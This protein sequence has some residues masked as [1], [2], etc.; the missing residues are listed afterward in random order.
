MNNGN[1]VQ[2]VR[3]QGNG[4]DAFR[5]GYNDTFSPWSN[6]NDQKS[7]KAATS[8]GFKL[9]NFSNNI[10]TLNIYNNLNEYVISQNTTLSTGFGILAII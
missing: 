9:N 10:Y 2:D 7:D 5:I 1:P 3:Y 8:F 6:P 4:F